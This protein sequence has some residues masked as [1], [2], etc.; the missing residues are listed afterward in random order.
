MDAKSRVNVPLNK[1]HGG[2][3][4]VIAAEAGRRR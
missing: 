2:K 4:C 1:L 3:S